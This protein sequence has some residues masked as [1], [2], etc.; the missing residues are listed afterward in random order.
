MV[1]PVSRESVQ[2]PADQVCGHLSDV[3]GL[4]MP[5]R[6]RLLV[7]A[8]HLGVHVADTPSPVACGP[9]LRSKAGLHE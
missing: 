4:P 3:D 6:E 9:N 5:V 8:R 2:C 1:R 7:V